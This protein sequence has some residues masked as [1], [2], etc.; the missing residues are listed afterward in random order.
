VFGAKDIYDVMAKSAG[1]HLNGV[2]DRIRVPFL[3]THGVDD[4]Q[5]PREYAQQSHDQMVNSPKRELKIFTQHEGGVHHVSL[6]N[7]SNAGNH[8]ADWFGETLGGHAG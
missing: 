5:I 4:K 3:V 6:D 2:L 1:M 7:M 8:I